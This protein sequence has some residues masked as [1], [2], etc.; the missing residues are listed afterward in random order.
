M[1]KNGFGEHSTGSLIPTLG[2]R[3]AFLPDSLPP[4][5]IDL[6]P[7][8][9]L[10][11][12]ATQNIGELKGI[13]RT[14]ANPMVLVRPL[15]RREAV[16]SSGMEGTYTT[17]S[18]LLLLEAGGK[19]AG[20]RNETREVLNYARALEQSIAD[21]D[22]LP[23]SSRMIR[24]AHRTL[25]SG[26]SRHR[27]AKIEPGEFKRDQNWIGGSGNIENARFIPAPPKETPKAIDEL[28][29]YI[30][31]EGREYASPLVDAAMAHYQFE[32]IH[33][34]ADGNGRV[35]RMLIALM[36]ADYETLPQPLLYMSPWLEGH[37]DRY[38]DTMYEVSRSGDWVGWLEFFLLAVAESASETISVVEQLQELQTSYHEQFQTARRSALILKIIDLAFER[39]VLRVTDIAE[40]LEVTYAGAANNVKIL[41]REGVAVEIPWA[42]P[43]TIRFP[44]I[45]DALTMD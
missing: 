16:S 45:I 17:L 11:S 29:S 32:A 8:L 21:L 23:I 9:G 42:Y 6:S 41:L 18:D 33:P 19:A 38:I 43:K 12:Q 27:G 28:M 3:K 2:G 13:G 7:L 20:D 37:K 35:G 4:K 24:N 26:V 39:P 34:F 25:L 22:N 44:E 40:K 10:L 36:L 5:S 15:Q 30:N 31:R 14:I 1:D